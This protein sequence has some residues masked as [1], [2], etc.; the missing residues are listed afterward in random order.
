MA[1]AGSH[2]L[3]IPEH[4]LVLGGTGFVGAAVARAFLASGC[5]VSIAARRPASHFADLPAN[6]SMYLFDVADRPALESALADVE[7]VVY[8]LGTPFAG[9]AD[10]D[11]IA[12]VAGTLPPLL[13][14]LE[15]LRDRPGVALTFLSSG[16]TVYGNPLVNPVSEDAPCQPITGYGIMKLA[17]EKY[18]SMYADLH[19]VRSRILR[20]S[21]AY[22]PTQPSGRAQGLIAELLRAAREGGAV[23]V[24]GDGGAVRDFVFVDDVASAVVNLSGLRG[25][26]LVLNVGS[27]RGHSVSEVISLFESVTGVM[28]RRE[29]RPVRSFDVDK[30]VLDVSGLRNL[31]TW[32]PLDL[33]EG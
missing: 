13:I 16:G 25:G 10:R 27:G 11:P 24:F 14:L 8:S 31:M 23:A 18:V 33:R 7:H 5:T 28:I 15:V 2:A 22:G 20:V 3:A 26:P 32:Q 19:S 6:G 4:V 30:I 9:A 29:Y 21:N 1:S 17:A 12:N